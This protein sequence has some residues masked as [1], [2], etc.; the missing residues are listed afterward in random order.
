VVDCPA[1]TSACCTNDGDDCF[2]LEEADCT[3]FGG[4]WGAPGGSC[5]DVDP[6]SVVNPCPADI[7]GSG[8]VGV[9]DVLTVLSGW[10]NVGPSPAD[11]NGD[12]IVNVDDLLMVISAWGPCVE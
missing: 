9:D 10:G 8:V 7:D 4:E 2:V 6:C 11:V 3:L 1:P 12:G 5:D